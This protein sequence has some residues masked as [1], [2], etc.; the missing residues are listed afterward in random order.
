MPF[1]VT[2]LVVDRVD[3][4]DEGANSAA[5]IELYKRKEQKTSMDIKELISKL[6]PEHAEIVNAELTRLSEDVTKAKQEVEELTTER[7]EAVAKAKETETQLEEISKKKDEQADEEAIIKAMPEQARE[8]YLT[9]RKQKEAAE[10]QVRKA[11]EAEEHATA[12]AKAKELKSLPVEQDELVNII[13]SSNTDVIEML[14]G[15]SKAIE[16]NVL[17]EVGKSAKDADTA[18]AWAQIESKAVEIAKRDGVTKEKAI[19]VAMDENPELYKRYLQGGA[20]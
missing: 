5:F 15:I 3:L 18:D 20:R 4:V 11:K 7:D 17:T 6:K 8:A 13:K 2:D 1:V 12:V 10:E 16:D 14:T 19:S 9:M